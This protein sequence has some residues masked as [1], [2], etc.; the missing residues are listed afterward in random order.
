MASLSFTLNGKRIETTDVEPHTTLLTWLREHGYT[1]SKEGCAEGEC[2]AC[3]VLLVT[4]AQEGGSRYVAANGCLLLTA[5]LDGQEII[6]VEGLGTPTD[7]HPVQSAM[8]A[9]GGSQCGYCTPGFVVSMASEYYRA[10]RDGFHLEAIGGNLCRCTGYRPIR[11]AALT[12]GTPDATDPLSERLHRPAPDAPSFSLQRGPAALY[13]PAS[14]DELFEVLGGHP[15]AKLVAG[16]TDWVVD[17]NQRASRA[18]TQVAIDRVPELRAV[19]WAE[20]HVEIGA[21]VTLSDLEHHLQGRIPLLGQLFPLFAS[22]LIRNRATL[23]GNVGTASPIGDSPPVLLALGADV[24]LASRDGERTL[25][26]QEFFVGYRRSAL[27]GGEVIRAVRVPLPVVNTAR[28][29]KVAKRPMDD[30]ST[31]A[32]AFAF[33]LQDGVVQT[34][35]I[36]LGGVAATPARAY[37]TEDAL[38]GQPW[39]ERTLR[40]AQDVLLGEF[41]PISDHRGSAGYRHA[42]LPRLLEKFFVETQEVP[43]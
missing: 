26:L 15:D 12:L 37:R 22:V 10:D 42:M 18:A 38:V 19:T 6:T 20:D 16:G 36:G 39:D 41:T 11:D 24:I 35:R 30:I 8:A 23:G 17:V 43:A 33:E 1:G 32:A 27:Q 40:A 3:A 21:G 14:L 13:R 9:A 4:T 2:G 25:P 29:Y 7:L 31:V 28:F 34:A 5:A